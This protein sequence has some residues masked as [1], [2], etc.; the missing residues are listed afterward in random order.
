MTI[1]DDNTS[2]QCECMDHVSPIVTD[3]SKYD[4]KNRVFAP[5]IGS[6]VFK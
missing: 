1:M 4:A 3:L 5:G 6:L 2:F